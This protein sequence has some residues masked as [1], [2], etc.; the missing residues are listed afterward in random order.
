[1]TRKLGHVERELS[2]HGT[3]LATTAE[4]MKNLSQRSDERLDY[5]RE[6]F[7]GL[8]EDNKDMFDI[9]D[10][11]HREMMQARRR[12]VTA[13]A[14]VLATAFTAAWFAVIV[15]IMDDVAVLERR[16]ADAEKRIV[17]LATEPEP[18]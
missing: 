15:P 1:M 13:G 12:I 11:R 3:A 16:L 4:Q 17:R 8:A 6:R 7:D 10:E 5:I 2:M 18:E 9:L 14:S